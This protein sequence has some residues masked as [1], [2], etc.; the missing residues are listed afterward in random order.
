[1]FAEGSAIDTF[2]HDRWKAP[3]RVGDI[4]PA[5]VVGS[6]GTGPRGGPAASVLLR[7]GRYYVEIAKS[8]YEWTRKKGPD[9]LKPGDL[10][11]VRI[12]TIDE[13]GRFATA[14]P[15]QDRTAQG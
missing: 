11:P 7:A 2:Q 14:T 4:V 8:G 15:D 6:G 10:V 1:M 13:D 3:I 5:V 12:L 9:F